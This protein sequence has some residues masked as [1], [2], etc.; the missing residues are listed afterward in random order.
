MIY[1]ILHGFEKHVPHNTDEVRYKVLT[2]AYRFVTSTDFVIGVIV[3]A[4]VL[5]L[6]LLPT[7][8]AMTQVNIERASIKELYVEFNGTYH[9]YA[10]KLCAG[11]K[12]LRYAK[13]IVTSDSSMVTV[14]VNKTI[15]ENKCRNFGVNITADNVDSIH[16][17]LV[18]Q[19]R[20]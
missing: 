12:P 7:A 19:I 15:K 4:L 17:K 10:F 14:D 20:A 1:D 8:F 16:A 5:A 2:P 18:K 3:V 9:L 11:D 13:I 6:M